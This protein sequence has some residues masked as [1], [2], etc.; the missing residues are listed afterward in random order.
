M[1]PSR[2]HGCYPICFKTEDNDPAAHAGSASS[3]DAMAEKKEDEKKEKLLLCAN[4]RRAIT[5]PS[6]KTSIHNA[7]QHAFTNPSGLVFEIGCFKDAPGCGYIGEPSS[8]FTWFQGYQ[9]RVAVCR[10]CLVHLGWLFSSPG[11]SFHGLILSAL[12][13]SD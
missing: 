12:I 2:I 5:R 3:A 4:C 9:W 11:L 10:N 13:I 8:E 7:H 6:E 1:K